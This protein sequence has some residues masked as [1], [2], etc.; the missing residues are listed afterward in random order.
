MPIDDLKIHAYSICINL[1]KY[2]EFDDKTNNEEINIR[3]DKQ[4]REC[5]KQE[6]GRAYFFP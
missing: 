6:V 5:G 4:D 2:V 3:V 1:S